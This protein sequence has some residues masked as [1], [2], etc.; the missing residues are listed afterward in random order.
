MGAPFGVRGWNHLCSFTQ[1]I[2]NLLTY[3]CWYLKKQEEWV[4]YKVLAARRHGAGLVAQ[5]EG[6]TE[7]EVAAT[8]SLCPIAVER[9]AF[10]LLSQDT[11]Y[12]TDLEGLAVQTRAGAVCGQVAYLYENAGMQVMVVRQG[13]REFHVP[14]FMHET[15]VH[16]D[17]EAGCIVVDWIHMGGE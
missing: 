2:E 15:I 14:F 5:L 6:N 17:L 10:P 12:W 8:L 11:Y 3:K 4:A 9:G 16:V 13:T 1:P 7:R